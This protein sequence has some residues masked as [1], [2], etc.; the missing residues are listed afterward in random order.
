MKRLVPL[1]FVP[2]LASV[3]PS[4]E[5]RALVAMSPPQQA[6]AGIAA[7]ICGGFQCKS[8]GCGINLRHPLP[9]EADAVVRLRLTAQVVGVEPIQVQ[10]IRDAYI[11]VTEHEGLLVEVY[12][13]HGR[14]GPLNA[15]QTFFQVGDNIRFSEW[16]GREH[17]VEGLDPVGS[18]WIVF[19][20]WDALRDRF[21]VLAGEHGVVAI[22]GG[23]VRPLGIL[24]NRWNDQPVEEFETALTA[25]IQSPSK[26]TP[27][28]F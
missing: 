13:H 27:F 21:R 20:K 24:R 2:L 7:P 22:H 17:P 19:L 15:V 3:A 23:V 1:M 14:I 9:V 28:A 6:P 5:Q 25:A 11:I 12:K 4:G 18:E 8:A 10:P 16:N 26:S